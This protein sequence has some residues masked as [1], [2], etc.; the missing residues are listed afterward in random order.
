MSLGKQD[1][2]S[3]HDLEAHTPCAGHLISAA[4]PPKHNN[5]DATN[6]FCAQALHL[7]RRRHVLWL[8]GAMSS[9]PRSARTRGPRW[10]SPP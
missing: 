3:W 6:E 4:H 7:T 9:L 5:S 8:Y 2:A 10:S 1:E